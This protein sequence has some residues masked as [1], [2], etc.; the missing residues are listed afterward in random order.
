MPSFPIRTPQREYC[1]V[2]ER[3][4]LARVAEYIPAR[5]GKVFVV[6][7]EDV[8]CHQ[9][10]NFAHGLS[11]V[12]HEVV[13]LPGAVWY[14]RRF[15]SGDR[16]SER[17]KRELYASTRCPLPSARCPRPNVTEACV[18]DAKTSARYE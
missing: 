18:T 3:G 5:S 1:A 2:V 14:T 6:T 8:W 17:V 15:P 13:F 10:G 16:S 4:I 11:T 7:T 9:G 12:P